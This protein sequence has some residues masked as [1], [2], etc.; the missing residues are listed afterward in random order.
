MLTNHQKIVG[1]ERVDEIRGGP[2]AIQVHVQIV[3]RGR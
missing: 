2:T 3:N 1:V